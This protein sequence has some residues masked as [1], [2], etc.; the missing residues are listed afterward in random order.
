MKF[1]IGGLKLTLTII[2]ALL[3]ISGGTIRTEA[4]PQIKD[5]LTLEMVL[6]GLRSTSSG[7]SLATK[8]EF[9]K[10]RVNE[11][12]VDFPLIA[13]VEKDLR[14]NGASDS[15]IATIRR[16][17]PKVVDEKAREEAR[18][19]REKRDQEILTYTKD[20]AKNPKDA[21]AFYKRAILYETQA[22]Y[23]LALEDYVRA[24]EIKPEDQTTK[25]RLNR[26][27]DQI[28]DYLVTE[29]RRDRDPAFKRDAYVKGYISTGKDRRREMMLTPP[30]YKG[31]GDKSFGDRKELVYV[32]AFVNE[33]GRIVSAIEVSN[34]FWLADSAIR[35]AKSSSF[36]ERRSSAGESANDWV[37]IIYEYER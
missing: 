26:I 28:G 35:A 1:T 24:L 23:Q 31:S 21:E 27:L 15:L 14:T 16:K 17:A 25:Y 33:K 20:I 9:I 11:L 36:F 4:Q 19:R 29:V 32:L 5:P 12:G 3:I 22:D 6:T 10:L 13:K 30:F 34:K 37:I 18:Q 8:N 7:V 2:F